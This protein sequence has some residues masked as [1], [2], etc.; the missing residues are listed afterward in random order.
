MHNVACGDEMYAASWMARLASRSWPSITSCGSASHPAPTS[1]RSRSSDMGISSAI[2][3]LIH[4]QHP[5]IALHW[6]ECGG[7]VRMWRPCSSNHKRTLLVRW[8][9][10]WS[11]RKVRPRSSSWWGRTCSS[12]SS[13]SVSAVNGSSNSANT[14]PPFHTAPHT[15]TQCGRSS[16]LTGGVGCPRG[17][18]RPCPAWGV[19]GVLTAV[20]PG[21]DE[22]AAVLPRPRLSL[23]AVRVGVPGRDADQPST[24][25]ELRAAA[26]ESPLAP[27]ADAERPVARRGSTAL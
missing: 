2:Y 8:T 7:S 18:Q 12:S 10:R 20:H 15:R 19:D 26:G 14:E 23:R 25:V 11:R 5:S 1:A 16:A 24:G 9:R 21:V 27:A 17:I 3:S 13:M 6:R 4:F 22:V